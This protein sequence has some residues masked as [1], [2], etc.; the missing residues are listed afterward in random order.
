MNGA[1]KISRNIEIE[2]LRGVAVTMVIV[3]H[4]IFLHLFPVFMRRSFNGVDLFFAISGYVV[5]LSLLKLLPP[6]THISSFRDR[7]R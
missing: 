3:T 7:L 6:S 2:R 5:T 4:G 1:I